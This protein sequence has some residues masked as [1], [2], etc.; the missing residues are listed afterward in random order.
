MNT[1]TNNIYKIYFK[2]HY[3]RV[4]EAKKESEHALKSQRLQEGVFQGYFMTKDS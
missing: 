3:L 1:P 4:L 2:I